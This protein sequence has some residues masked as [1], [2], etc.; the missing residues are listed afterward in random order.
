MLNDDF[1]LAARILADPDS[2]PTDGSLRRA[3]SSAYYALFHTVS[4]AFADLLVGDT[5]A[6][7]ASD[8]WNQAYRALDHRQLRR[9][10]ARSSDVLRYHPDLRRF[11][12]TFVD[13]QDLRHEADY[14][15]HANFD[16]A[17]VDLIIDVAASAMSD[18]ASAPEDERRRF[19]V[20]VSLRQR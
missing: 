19:I 20:Y 12:Q 1:L 18:F 9:Q 4:N 5:P 17:R 14:S 11:A 7:R 13:L 3:A 10:C 16:Q 8:E 2:N 6:A 15:P